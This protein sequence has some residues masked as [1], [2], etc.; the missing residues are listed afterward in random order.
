MTFF[1][2]DAVALFIAGAILGVLFSYVAGMFCGYLLNIEQTQIKFCEL[3]VNSNNILNQE[4]KNQILIQIYEKTLA[5]QKLMRLI[6][7]ILFIGIIIALT[8]V[9]YY[10]MAI[11]YTPSPCSTS[12][13]LTQN[14][15]TV[16]NNNFQNFTYNITHVF[17]PLSIEG[18]RAS[19][20]IR[21]F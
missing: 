11:P 19:L 15:T 12:I 7:F 18:L 13:N 8:M 17:H 1:L 5:E 6:Y 3:Q 9:F 20:N 21:K 2:P 10:I 14:Y 16:N 4:A